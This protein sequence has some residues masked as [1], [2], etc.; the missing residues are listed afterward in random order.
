M[1]LAATIT[2]TNIATVCSPD[3]LE[4]S[5]YLIDTAFTLVDHVATDCHNYNSQK[6]VLSCK[7]HMHVGCKYNK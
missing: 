7:D 2:T 3:I 4:P 1:I 5:P 6:E